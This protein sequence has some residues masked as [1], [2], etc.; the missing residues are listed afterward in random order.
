MSWVYGWFDCCV[1]S[2]WYGAG[3]RGG[4]FLLVLLL[5]TADVWAFQQTRTSLGMP[6]YWGTSEIPFFVGKGGSRD[7]EGDAA[8]EAI[9]QAAAIWSAVPC[10]QARLVFQGVVEKPQASYTA[11]GSNQNV[12]YWVEDPEPW[13]DSLEVLAL[14]TINYVPATGELQDAD[15]QLNGRSFRWSTKSPTPAG[16]HDIMNT[17]VHEFGHVL[18]LEHSTDTDATMYADSPPGEIKKRD[19]ASDDIDGICSIYGKTPED[20]LRFEVVSVEDGRRACPEP[21]PSYEA[22][23]PKQGCEASPIADQS[24]VWCWLVLLLWWMRRANLR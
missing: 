10:S 12:V 5:R 15:M 19:L 17:A 2:V 21:R 16:L 22:P 11:G 1:R 3:W 14:T 8:I 7:V 24:A 23:P 20:R 13:P 6:V 9:K 4:V 18:G